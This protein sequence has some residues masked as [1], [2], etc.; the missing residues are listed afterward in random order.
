M[1]VGIPIVLRPAR[2]SVMAHRLPNAEEPR[3]SS[4]RRWKSVT[5]NKARMATSNHSSVRLIPRSVTEGNRAAGCGFWA[6]PYLLQRL[7]C[8][9]WPST[10]ATRRGCAAPFSDLDT[11]SVYL[12]PISVRQNRRVERAPSDSKM[13]VAKPHFLSKGARC[14]IPASTNDR[15]HEG[16]ESLAKHPISL[17]RSSCQVRPLFRLIAGTAR[18]RRYPSRFFLERLLHCGIMRPNISNLILGCPF[19]PYRQ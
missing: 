4:Q 3:A 5:A 17:C 18:T 16:A 7:C 14:D 11:L 12:Q 13:L 15:R 19:L 1:F 9:S 6:H 10:Y 2:L 8:S